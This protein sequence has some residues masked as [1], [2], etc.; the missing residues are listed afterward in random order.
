MK[1]L[2]LLI[3][4]AYSLQAAP[5]GVAVMSGVSGIS[6]TASQGSPFTVSGSVEVT[7]WPSSYQ[8]VSLFSSVAIPVSVTSFTATTYTNVLSSPLATSLPA[9]TDA[10]PLPVSATVSGMLF[11]AAGNS[12][13]DPAAS[14]LAVEAYPMVKDDGSGKFD[15]VHG[16]DVSGVWVNVKASS[17][18]L[19]TSLPAY[20]NTAPLPVRL[21]STQFITSTL[22]NT[23]VQ[24]GAGATFTGTTE[25][26]FDQIGAQVMVVCDQPYT[27]YVDQYDGANNLVDTDTFTRSAGQATNECI[28]INGD[29]LRVRVTNNGA[30]STTTLRVETT[31][32]PLPPYPSSASNL[33]NFKTALNEINGV[34]PSTGTGL[35]DSGTLRVALS[36]PVGVAVTMTSTN[37]N[38]T[39]TAAGYAAALF[40]M[41][42]GFTGTVVAEVS[43]NMTDWSGVPFWYG[44]AAIP[45]LVTSQANPATGSVAVVNS[46]G[47]SYVRLRPSA[48]TSGAAVVIGIPSMFGPVISNTTAV[49][50]AANWS[51]NM[52]QI[53]GTNIVTGG[54]NGLMGVAGNV[55]VTVA[56]AGNPIKIGFR[57]VTLT[58]V[59]VSHGARVDALADKNGRQVVVPWAFRE[60]VVPVT[61]TISSTSETAISVSGTSGV[62]RDIEYLSVSNG[63]TQT[64]RCDLRSTWGGTVLHSIWLAPGATIS[65]AI[66]SIIP[67]TTAAS[68]WTAQFSQAAATN[69]FRVNL[70]MAETN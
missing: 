61:T 42:A 56:D 46:Y 24:L 39:V 58:S 34:V 65:E 45:T 31:Y 33:G 20:T 29:A 38:C 47:A 11:E 43:T 7:S 2:F 21:A 68:A 30:G 5:D 14:A 41:K 23:T 18:P 53:G 64:V 55:S 44:S 16:D 62:F 4:M 40:Q 69:D 48:Y 17:A 15:V 54:V 13:E 59:A 36:G 22:N 19:G 10:T 49:T 28:Q 12:G 66:G 6:V 3:S 25:T 63:S 50:A 67:Q 57:G 9:Y 8:G 32:G 52:N 51:S 60:R 70:I 1:L 37:N 27:V 26:A 35:S